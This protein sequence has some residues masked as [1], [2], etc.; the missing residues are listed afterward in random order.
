MKILNIFLRS[1][2]DLDEIQKQSQTLGAEWQ[3]TIKGTFFSSMYIPVFKLNKWLHIEK[4]YEVDTKFSQRN[5][6]KFREGYEPL[7]YAN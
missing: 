3:T 7:G 1:D 2:F 6:W 4:D 5:Y